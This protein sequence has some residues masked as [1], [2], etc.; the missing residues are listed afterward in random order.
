VE[1]VL[2]IIGHT[3]PKYK[4]MLKQTNLLYT[5]ETDGEPLKIR[6]TI[7]FTY[8]EESGMYTFYPSDL[9]LKVTFE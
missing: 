4:T 5:I 2:D 3:D 9:I 7:D 8:D 6:L 1:Q